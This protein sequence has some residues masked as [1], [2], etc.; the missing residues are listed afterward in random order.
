M[1][2]FPAL[3]PTRRSF[4]PGEY[5]HTPFRSLN[6]F[7]G[8][9]RHSNV[10]VASTLNL[11]FVGL[12]EADL[13]DILLH[14]QDSQGIYFS[15]ALPE[16]ILSGLNAADF[17]LSGFSWRYASP[18]VV[19]DLPCDRYT[20]DVE[21]ESVESKA[22]LVL[23][24]LRRTI[25]VGLQT[26]G[27][28]AANGFSKTIAVSFNTSEVVVFQQEVFLS[29]GTWDWTAAGSPS[30]V[31]V[32]LVGGGG[33][34]GAWRGGGG[35]AGGVKAAGSVAVTGNVTV[36][37]GSGGNGN[38]GGA[39]PTAAQTGGL[40]SFG[41]QQV[42]GG[43]FGGIGENDNNAGG[44][45]GSGGGAGGAAV[46]NAQAPGTGTSGQ[47]S[48]GGSSFND[49]TATPRAGGGGG[50]KSASG[51][52][53]SSGAGGN[54]GNGVTLESLGFD[55][56]V[57]LGAP[58][59]VGGGGGGSSSSGTSG[60]GGTGGGGSGSVSGNATSG[61]ANTGGGGGGAGGGFESSFQGGAGGSGLVVVRWVV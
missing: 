38:T 53:A 56:A 20:V 21:F 12:A 54:G 43:G 61:T 18:P 45:G 41:T 33:G 36:T 30:T 6:G 42:A 44:N 2:T 51:Q 3:I 9:V 25:S 28:F 40:S 23:F 1:S 58:S 35:G 47:G 27:A 15:F 59:S 49:S 50:G 55:T 8:R 34:G 26:G 32:L 39:T 37:V 48:N 10:M 4:T 31:D 11:T 13:L 22:A 57:L 7:E 19:Q 14:Y 46:G 16:D 24:G 29:S 60:A 5:P 52:N 17:T